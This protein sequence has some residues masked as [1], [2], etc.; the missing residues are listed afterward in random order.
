MFAIS[1]LVLSVTSC[2]MPTTTQTTYTVKFM[3]KN[4]LLKEEIYVDY[5]K[6]SEINIEIEKLE[7]ELE[8]S[9]IKWE[10]IQEKLES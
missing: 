10:E 1:L 7:T 9:L 8:E 2:Q 5:I 6:V 3:Y 4:E